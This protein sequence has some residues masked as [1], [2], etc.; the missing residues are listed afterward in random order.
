MRDRETGNPLSKVEEN[1]FEDRQVLSSA[2]AGLISQ[3]DDLTNTVETLR[4]EVKQQG[5]VVQVG[6]DVLAVVYFF[7]MFGTSILISTLLNSF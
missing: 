1:S 5:E 2:I 3:A 6:E 4:Q 7:L